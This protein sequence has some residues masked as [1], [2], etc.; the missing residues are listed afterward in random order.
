MVNIGTL[1]YVIPK[2]CKNQLSFQ[3]IAYGLGIMWNLI[4]IAGTK[5]GVENISLIP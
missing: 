2:L 5:N 1:F 3:K 4:V